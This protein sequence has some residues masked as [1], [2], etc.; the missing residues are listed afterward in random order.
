MPQKSP[1]SIKCLDC[2]Y[3]VIDNQKH[4]IDCG[5]EVTPPNLNDDSSPVYYENTTMPFG[6][7]TL[8]ERLSREHRDHNDYYYKRR[9]L[10]PKGDNY[11]YPSLERMDANIR[12]QSLLRSMS[13]REVVEYSLAQKAKQER[14]E[15]IRC[16]VKNQLDRLDITAQFS[17]SYDKIFS[18]VF[19]RLLSGVKTEDWILREVSD[20]NMDKVIADQEAKMAAY[21][22][23][24]REEDESNRLSKSVLEVDFIRSLSNSVYY[25]YGKEYDVD[26]GR[27][28]YY[29]YG[30]SAVDSYSIGGHSYA[31]LVYDR[32]IKESFNNEFLKTKLASFDKNTKVVMRESQSSKYEPILEYFFNMYSTYLQCTARVKLFI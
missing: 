8:L 11:V 10:C 31:V 16:E 1:I 28:L 29:G 6:L 32:T 23:K 18:Y 30:V 13:I 25:L 20:I 15:A 26:E 27:E 22:K 7:R 24:R 9:R 3:V 5:Y 17:D 19:R 2:E 21:R 4:T 12:E 14:E